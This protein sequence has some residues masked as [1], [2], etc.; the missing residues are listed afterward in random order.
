[1]LA[2]CRSTF[3]VEEMLKLRCWRSLLKKLGQFFV[4]KQVLSTETTLTAP[5]RMD[6]D[7]VIIIVVRTHFEINE[8]QWH[9]CLGKRDCAA[10]DPHVH[11][12]AFKSSRCFLVV[13][14]PAIKCGIIICQTELAT[15]L[16]WPIVSAIHVRND[17]AS[18]QLMV[19][20]IKVR[21]KPSSHRWPQC[22][23][24]TNPHVVV[25]ELHGVHC[26]AI[27]QLE[28]S[29]WLNKI[30]WYICDI[31]HLALPKNNDKDKKTAKD[32]EKLLSGENLPKTNHYQE[33]VSNSG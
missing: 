16:K 15:V 33:Q 32:K 18:C 23:P 27:F 20:I 8:L 10:F 26:E 11:V 29:C 7:T 30:V 4:E 9:N 21:Q 14:Q 3:C 17:R 13:E 31:D 5:E 28:V 24:L 6:I 25:V 12:D 1:M 19:A 22:K 2:T